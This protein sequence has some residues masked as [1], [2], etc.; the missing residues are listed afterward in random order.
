MK[1]SNDYLTRI[2]TNENNVT[3]VVRVFIMVG[4]LIAASFIQAC[5]TNVTTIGTNP[6]LNKETVQ[7]NVYSTSNTV[8]DF[9]IQP[10]IK[11]EPV[12]EPVEVKAIY[13]TG[14]SAG[15]DTRF[16]QLLNL[17]NST[18][19]NAMV[20]DIKDEHGITHNSK[21]PIAREIGATSGRIKDPVKILKTL[22]ENNIYPIARIVVFKDAVLAKK[23]PELAV[24]HKNGGI[25]KDRKGIPWADPYN[26]EVWE[27]NIALAEEAARLGFKEVQFDY[28]RFPSDGDIKSAV[29]ESYNGQSRSEVIT[30]FLKYAK[31]RLEPRGVY[32]SA[33]VFGLVTSSTDDMYIGQFLEDIA[34]V[35]DYICP[36]VYPSH[37]ALGSYGIPNPDASPY[38]TVYTSLSHAVNRLNR[39]EGEKAIIRPWL[40][41]FTLGYKYGPD[42]VKAQIRAVY[43]A[44]LKEWILWN[45]SN[46]YTV[47]ALKRE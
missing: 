38:E 15:N 28:I 17:V 35:V 39:M 33:D 43:D 44:G 14:Y 19:L 20:I 10:N 7:G 41:D 2:L 40:Q 30:E 18:E 24:K 8:K 21:V 45:P 5:T 26:K 46:Y 6:N 37:Y 34:G 25:W 31:K 22:K 13:L 27:Y 23:K 9:L 4:F 42:E 1:L 47:G 36:M 32:V 16:K 11:V 12:W 29:Y 3:S